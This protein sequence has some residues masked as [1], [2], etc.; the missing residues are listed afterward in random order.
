MTNFFE[1]IDFQLVGNVITTVNPV[2]GLVIKGLDTI[3][4]SDN[5]TVSNDST[6]KILETLSKSTDNNVDDKLI[7]MVKTYLECNKDK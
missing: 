3:V 6:I 2:A 5:E 7:C 4:N 1:D